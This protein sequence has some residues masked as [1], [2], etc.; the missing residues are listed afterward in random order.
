MSKKEMVTED[1]DDLEGI[2][3]KT[4]TE[5]AELRRRIEEKLCINGLGEFLL[6]VWTQTF[7]SSHLQF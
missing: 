7:L 3:G 4:R 1:N 6:A 2:A 5:S